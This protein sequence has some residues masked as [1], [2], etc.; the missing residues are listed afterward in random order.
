MI[1]FAIHNSQPA[2]CEAKPRLSLSIAKGN[3]L[4]NPYT[5]IELVAVIVIAGMLSTFVVM[6]VGKLPA[7]ISLESKV[8]EFSKILAQARN[9]AACQGI[10]TTVVFDAENHRIFM[11]QGSNDEQKTSSIEMSIPEEIKLSLNNEE[12][13]AEGQ[14]TTL[15]KFYPDG[16][17]G[18]NSVKLELKKH[19]FQISISPLSGSVIAEELNN[20]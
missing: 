19:K 7:F 5:L 15:F 14:N 11:P 3:I 8:N 17:G 6:R 18:G 10:N 13:E 16:S 4:R 1:F 12:I 2:L 9:S 20:E